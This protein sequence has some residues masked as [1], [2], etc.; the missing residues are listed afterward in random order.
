MD[1]TRL[2]LARALNR[3]R[4]NVWYPIS[5]SGIWFFRSAMECLV[6]TIDMPVQGGSCRR[7]WLLRQPPTAREAHKMEWTL[8]ALQVLSKS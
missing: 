3:S 7:L 4:I 1:P 6:V 5:F 8:T 2:T